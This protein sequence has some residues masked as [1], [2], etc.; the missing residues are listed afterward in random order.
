[1]GNSIGRRSVL[2]GA[3]LSLGGVALLADRSGI[4]YWPEHRTLVVAD[5]HLE[6][7]SAYATRGVMLPPYDST[8]TLASLREAIE[9]YQ[10]RGVI[11]LGDSFHDRNGGARLTDTN[12]A[13][14]REMQSGRDWHWISGNHD[15]DRIENVG[16]DFVDCLR[17]G[18]LVFRHE[19]ADEENE[20]VGHFHPVARISLRGRSMRR[21]CF[22]SSRGR[23]VMP[24][25]GAFAGG[26]NVRDLTFAKLLGADFLAHMLGAERPHTFAAAHC[27]PD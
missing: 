4:L 13:R 17:I 23:L 11:A 1:M 20:I 26:L 3:E 21:R 6:K 5:L 10:P 14:L 7:G 2:R 18:P 27:L 25:F 19:P 9:H 16:G 22:V 24:A 8:A 12:H 15:P